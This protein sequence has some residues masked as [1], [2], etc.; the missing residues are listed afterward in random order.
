MAPVLEI[1]EAHVQPLWGSVIAPG[2]ILKRPGSSRII[3]SNTSS[4]FS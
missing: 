3:P 1:A 4:P 2:R